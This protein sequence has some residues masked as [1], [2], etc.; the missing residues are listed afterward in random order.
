MARGKGLRTRDRGKTEGQRLPGD[1]PA[2]E[3]PRSDR[4]LYAYPGRAR[5]L[6]ET[7]GTRTTQLSIERL[8]ALFL[9]SAL[10][11]GRDYPYP[12]AW[13]GCPFEQQVVEKHDFRCGVLKDNG[14]LKP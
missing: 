11:G 13:A 12:R 1:I 3:I 5:Y 6:A 4:L 8:L 10:L 7:I 2:G 14:E 9:A